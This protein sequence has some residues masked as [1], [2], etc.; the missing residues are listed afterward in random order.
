ME[1]IVFV[2][3]GDSIRQLAPDGKALSIMPLSCEEELLN[4]PGSVIVNRLDYEKDRK[5]RELKDI[6][7]SIMLD[8]FERGG[9]VFPLDADVQ[10]TMTQEFLGSQIMPG[11]FYEWKDRD[12]IY[13]PIGGA[14][15]FQ[16][17]VTA[18]LMYG[19]GLFAREGMLQAMIENAGTVEEV[20]AITWD[21]VPEEPV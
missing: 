12:G 21:T 7:D 10:L 2:D 9:F 13:R 20:Q 19:K 18:A 6:R 4:I 8:G 14:E 11:P 5:R 17:F 1:Q 16:A 15:D 3:F